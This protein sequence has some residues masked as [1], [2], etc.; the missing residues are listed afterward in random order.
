MR[1]S[2]VFFIGSIVFFGLILAAVLLAQSKKA[3]FN[4]SLIQPASLADDF[5]LTN[6]NGMPYRLQEQQGKAVVLFF[7]Y[8]NCPDFC[9]ATLAEFREIKA[10]LGEQA[11][12]VRFVFVTVDPERDTVSRLKDYVDAFDPE[13]TGLTGTRA[14]LEKVWKSYDVYQEKHSGHDETDITVDHSTRTYLIDP[15]GKLRLTYPF[16]FNIEMIVQDIQSLLSKQ[17]G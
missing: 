15:Q 1:S 14:E 4:G 5:Q 13:I 17:S 10:S 12:Q 8:T 16:G 6:Q 9:P 11:D 3:S 2:R 7:G